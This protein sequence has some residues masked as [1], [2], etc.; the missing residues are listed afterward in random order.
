VVDIGWQAI[1]KLNKARV[2]GCTDNLIKIFFLSVQ[3][4]RHGVS[5]LFIKK[6]T[7]RALSNGSKHIFFSPTNKIPNLTGDFEMYFNF[8]TKCKWGINIMDI[9]H[10]DVHKIYIKYRG[11]IPML[12]GPLGLTWCGAHQLTTHLTYLVLLMCLVVSK[13]WTHVVSKAWA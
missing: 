2:R 7:Q 13:L 3:C 10:M 9:V 12:S 8:Q 5:D 11:L 4:C 6:H 1:N